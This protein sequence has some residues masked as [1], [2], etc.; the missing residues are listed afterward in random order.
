V[1]NHGRAGAGRTP[2]L[3][4]AALLAAGLGAVTACRGRQADAGPSP[5]PPPYA[6]G[7][8][9]RA[10]DLDVLPGFKD[11]PP[12]YGEVAFYWWL[13][14]PLTKERLAW[15][16]DLL[17]GKGL[18]GLQINY[19]HSDKGGSSWGL[20]YPSDP[21]L[22]SQDWWALAGWFLGE[23][24]KRG[25]TV[26]LSDYTLG[27]G[28][29]FTADELLRA[30][31]ELA[32]T[33][34]KS[35][36]KDVAAGPVRWELPAGTLAVAAIDPSTGESEDLRGWA[37][38]GV[39]DW[40]APRPGR[41]LIAVFAE[42]V[43]PSIDPMNPRSGPAYAD[44]FFGQFERHMPGEPGRGLNFFFSDELD[45]RVSGPL[46][47][48]RFAAEFS[49]RK[50]Y[51]IIPLLPGLFEDIGPRTPKVR[52]DYGDVKAALSETGFFKPVFDWHQARGMIYGC[53]HGGRG[54]DVVEFGDYFRTQRWNQ[55][56]GCDQPALR[57]DLVKNKVASSIAHLYERPRTWLE[58]YHSS[59]WGTTTGEVADAT[60]ANFA[61]GQN[62]L[63]LHGLYYSTHGGWWEWAPPDNHWRMPYWA[64]M[65]AL[66]KC[67]ERLSYLL[68]Q[69]H[70]RADAAILYPVAPMEAG[71]GGREA[72][73]AAF[74]TAERLYRAGIDLDFID[75][76]SVARATIEGGEL[77]AGGERYRVLVLPAMRAVRWSTIEKALAFHRAGGL[78]LAIGALPE[79]SDRAGRD[80]P[81]LDA[82]VREL[83]ADPWRVLDSPSNAP[84]RV[85][86]AFPRD[87]A[88]ASGSPEF[89]HRRIG[90]RDVYM[91]YG[92]A[93]G[94]ECAFRAT[95]AVELWDPWTGS[96]RPLPVVEQ[97]GG[98]TRLR[99][100]LTETEVQ[101]IVFRPG[102]PVMDEGRVERRISEMPLEGEWA[103]AYKPTL[104]NRFGD[105]RW[106][107][108]D[109][110]IGPE[111]RRFRYRDETASPPGWEAAGLDDSSWSRVTYAF[112]TRFLQLGPLP[113]GA[114]VAAFERGLVARRA[115]ADGAA[116]RLGGRTYAWKP[117]DFSWRFGVEGDPGHQGYHG[118]KEEVPDEFIRL[119]KIVDRHTSYVRTEEAEG[120]R[121]YLWTTIA[122]PADTAGRLLAGGMTPA[123]LWLNGQAVPTGGP[124]TDVSLHKGANTL[125]VRYDGPGTGY[126]A[127][128]DTAAA[129]GPPAG[130]GAGSLEMRWSR[131]PG[132]LPFDVRP[133]AP[134]PAGWYRFRTAPGT[135][136]MIVTVIGRA[137]CWVDGTPCRAEDLGNGRIRFL[138]PDPRPGESVAAM[139]VEQARGTY[140]GAALVEPVAF[141]CGEGRMRPGDWSRL[142]SLESYSGGL[143]YT[144]TFDLRPEQLKGRA[145]L[146]LG[147]VV[148]SAEV[149]VNGMSAGIRVAPP[150]RWDITGRIRSGTN[151]VEVLVYNTLANHYVTI[152]TRY[153]G[154]AT[155][156]MLGRVRIVFEK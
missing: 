150:W 55:G 57:R 41:R 140:G 147:E 155:S 54:R 11:P 117:Y 49:R 90:P 4:L 102:R 48:A 31:P 156:G 124:S 67:T 35:E 60:F 58:G 98:T 133:G 15:Q 43:R 73:Q 44:A 36:A 75:F 39:L 10:Q 115:I 114:D 37:R 65:G 120:T 138:L 126:I 33:V 47:T 20:T 38:K 61:Q 30:E 129:A 83:F 22:F 96:T 97:S 142:E 131:M 144:R 26:S 143:S 134:A 94:T 62:L 105:F 72:V 24:K 12:G 113:A 137:E 32:G 139:R 71:L 6:V 109:G 87:F 89:V 1:R 23:A 154:R 104:D 106:P 107:A 145:L 59:G 21:P 86:A 46:W 25:L 79:A 119:G 19:A 123:A 132:L 152:P 81:E 53:D 148:S 93:K 121:Y 77:C 64:H 56:P 110:F 80:D 8:P 103:T 130:P 101:L 69:G 153:R 88:P 7:L 40:T 18:T 29:G 99:M 151:S 111:A 116:E 84:G 85:S 135:R 122:S 95:G 17:A 128:V 82:A 28:Q 149:L 5:P 63:T 13:G 141:E 76:E 92:L 42:T 91:V 136:S 9:S 125:I 50:G 74:D 16:L 34:L 100:P 70:H 68:S 27:I 52:L 112:G 66:L 3:A 146:D 2:V 78:A 45:F 127:A 51:D 14:D 108:F 118:L